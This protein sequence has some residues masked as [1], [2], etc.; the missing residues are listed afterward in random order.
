MSTPYPLTWQS[1]HISASRYF[2]GIEDWLNR[3]IKWAYYEL[4]KEKK[5]GPI[6]TNMER[7]PE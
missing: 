3:Y 5:S 4:K 6:Y 2:Q 1:M 7:Y